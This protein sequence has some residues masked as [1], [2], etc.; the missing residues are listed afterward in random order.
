MKQWHNAKKINESKIQW[1]FNESMTEFVKDSVNQ[2]TDDESVN[3]KF[4]ESNNRFQQVD[5]EGKPKD[6]VR[7]FPA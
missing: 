2:W 6:Q 4:N 7:Q 3:Q 1:T 5:E